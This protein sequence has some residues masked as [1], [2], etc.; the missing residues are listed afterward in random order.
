LEFLA[1]VYFPDTPGASPSTSRA[2]AI[3]LGVVAGIIG[4]LAIALL[5]R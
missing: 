2:W 3:A 1:Q 4:L 5:V